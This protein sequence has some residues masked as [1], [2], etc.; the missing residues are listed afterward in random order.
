MSSLSWSPDGARLASACGHGINIW[1]VKE[2]RETLMLRGH[3]DAATGVSWSP[4]GLRV[5]STGADRSVRIWDPNTGEETLLIPGHASTVFCD[6][7]WSPDGLRLARAGLE[8]VRIWDATLGY[9]RDHSP[10]ALPYLDRKIAA[11]AAT[12]G[13]NRIP[14]RRPGRDGRVG[15]LGH[16]LGSSC[17]ARSREPGAA[18]RDRLVDHRNRLPS[19]RQAEELAAPPAPKTTRV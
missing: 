11:G 16:R 4:D 15:P 9:E 7:A 6:V 14:G 10:R 13:R 5:A 17:S 2:G 1:N 18:A 12:F 19:T 3:T 8:D